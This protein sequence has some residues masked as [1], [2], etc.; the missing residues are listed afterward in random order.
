[1]VAP[2]ITKITEAFADALTR[3]LHKREMKMR[4]RWGAP[5]IAE[6][7][8]PVKVRRWRDGGIRMTR[9]AVPTAKRKYDAEIAKD[10]YR[11]DRA[12]Q[13]PGD[14]RPKKPA[15]EFKL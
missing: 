8:T 12:Y 9:R 10:K 4:N 13:R 6:N 14:P 3:G 2:F 7:T 15:F 11:Y 1:M 5:A